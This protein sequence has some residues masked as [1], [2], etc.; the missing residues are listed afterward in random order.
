MNVAMQRIA[1]G[2]EAL[3]LIFAARNVA[4]IGASSSPGKLGNLV[5]RLMLQSGFPGRIFPINRSASDIL[6]VPALQR[7]IDIPEPID[8]AVILV[9]AEQMLGALDECAAKGVPIVAAMTSGFAEAGEAGRQLERALMERLAHAPFRLLGPNCEGCVFP[10]NKS[11]I[12]FSPMTMGLADGRVGVVAQSGAISGAMVNRLGRMG[13]GIRAL[14][15]TGNECDITAADAL[16]WFAEDDATTTIICYLEQIRD[17]QRFVSIARALR[18]RKSIVVQKSGRGRAASEAVTTHTGAIAG[19]DRVIDGVFEELQIV[20]ASD[21]T[22]A[23]DA[24]AALSLGRRL[25]G[26]RVGIVSIA[27]GLAIES[28][29]LCEA[30]GF[31]VPRFDATVQA[32]LGTSLPSFAAVRNPVDL[33]GAALSSPGM[34]RDVI[35][36]VLEHG[37]IDA[38]IVVIT[39]SHQ[40]EFAD[41]LLAAARASTRPLLVVWT[42]PETLTPE[43]LAAFRAAGFPVFDA[44]A[45]AVTGLRALARSSGLA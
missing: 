18:G 16:E 45:R 26:L 41:V 17:A 5:V 39:F 25:D 8:V 6:G 15:T 14:V 28:C 30:A 7:L 31:E 22:T 3:D 44:P 27:G 12:T 36:I 33:T 40:A 11:F 20:R 21:H 29:D 9:P 43:P 23:V 13:I 19:D 35:E 38:L 42:A 32:R 37:G 1:T 2:R 24:A 34:F 4:I 10:A